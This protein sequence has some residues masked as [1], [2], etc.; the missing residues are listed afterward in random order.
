[1]TVTALYTTTSILLS[2]TTATALVTVT[3]PA[4][5]VTVTRTVAPTGRP[6]QTPSPTFPGVTRNCEY[7][8][9]K[10]LDTTDQD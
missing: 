4:S 9:S 2:T 6:V 5:T 1:M 10:L 7:Y 3:A 8:I